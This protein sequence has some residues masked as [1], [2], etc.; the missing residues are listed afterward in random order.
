MQHCLTSN[1]IMPL[2]D[3]QSCPDTGAPRVGADEPLLG[4]LLMQA[5]AYM[6][7]A[8]LSTRCSACISRTADPGLP[9]AGCYDLVPVKTLYS[10]AQGSSSQGQGPGQVR[11]DCH[12][13]RS[14]SMTLVH[15]A[16]SVAGF[17]IEERGTWR[18]SSDS[19]GC[20]CCL[21][22]AM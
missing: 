4:T 7:L 6:H 5:E 12:H 17:R 11:S 16:H 19:L 15:M 22:Y 18:A 10:K 14:L 13:V 8:C 3:L 9:K 2:V 21:A 20:T 1:I